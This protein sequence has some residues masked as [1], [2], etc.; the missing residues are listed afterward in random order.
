LSS[1]SGLSS[2]I[3]YR[4]Q[5]GTHESTA[6]LLQKLGAKPITQEELEARAAALSAR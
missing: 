5:Y 6:A 4:G 3:R 1:A 2:V